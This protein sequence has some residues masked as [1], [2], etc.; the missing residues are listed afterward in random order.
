[1]YLGDIALSYNY[2]N[3][4][5]KLNLELFKQKTDKIFIHGYFTF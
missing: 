4:R 3:K 2:L 5:S 1:M